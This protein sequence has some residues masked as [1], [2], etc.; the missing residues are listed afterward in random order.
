MW[1]VWLAYRLGQAAY[2]APVGV[3]AA[4]GLA[5]NATHGHYAHFIHPVTAMAAF[6]LLALWAAVRVAETGSTRALWV[7]AA[8][9]G[10][11]VSAQYHAGLGAVPIGVAVLQRILAARGA[12]RRLW[13]ARGLAAA[14]LAV[15]V[16]LVIS[17]Y[18]L[19]DFRTFRTDLAWITA[20]TGVGRYGVRRSLLGGL[21]R[22]RRTP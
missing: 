18:S 14:A 6:S 20:K 3:A 15:V 2:S 1:G 17:P 21:R 8:A 5:L 10:L 4:L 22:W 13:I 9:V 16:Y 11:G 12:E 19:L 7:G